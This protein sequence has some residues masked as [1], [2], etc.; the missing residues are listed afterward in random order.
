MVN[1]LGTAIVPDEDSHCECF[2]KQWGIQPAI[3][4]KVACQWASQVPLSV[5]NWPTNVEDI[6]DAGSILGSGRSPGGG[7]GN[8]LQ[9]SCLENPM[10]RG[11]WGL[12]TLGLHRVK[13]DWSDLVCMH[14]AYRRV[15]F[16][17]FRLFL[18]PGLKF[19]GL[20]FPSVKLL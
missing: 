8:P 3:F 20:W 19:L 2:R 16:L 1:W 14:T 17:I 6:R 7:H 5:K 4:Y 13:H 12:Q 10:D 18:T 11:A 9:C 15:F